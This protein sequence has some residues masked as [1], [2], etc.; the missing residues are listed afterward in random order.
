MAASVPVAVMPAIATAIPVF[1]LAFANVPLTDPGSR[2]T[3]S[4]P[5]MPTNAAFVVV[6]AAVVEPLYTLLL[7]V[8]PVTVSVLRVMFALVVG[9][10]SA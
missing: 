7:A 1:T 10:V 6:S 8:M 9:C 5:W 3:L 4:F 2:A